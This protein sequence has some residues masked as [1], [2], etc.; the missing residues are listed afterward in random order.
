MVELGHGAANLGNLYRPMSDEDAWA[1]LDAAWECGI[2]AFDTAPHYGL[3]LSERRLG[4]FLATKP[5][6]EY[7]VS[8]KVGRLLRPSPETADRL[9]EPNQFAVPASLKRV[10]DFSADGIRASLEE[11]LERLGLDKV[12]VV[13]L[14]DPDEHD[15]AADLAMG[16]PAVAA[17]RDEGL[18][19]AVGIGSKSTDALVAA[20]RT[21]GLDL[22][23]VAGRYTLL[24]QADEVVA[25]CR[26]T[27]VGIVAAAVFNSGL[28]AKPHPGG[29]YEYGDVPPEML[30]RARRI[31]GV[32]ERH[33]VTLPEAALQFPLREPAVRSVVVGA[34]TPEQVRENVRRMKVEIPEA[35]W[36][37]L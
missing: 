27:G 6:A 2:R 34:A 7:T 13:Y 19:T 17:L 25:A 28:L 29:R 16:V 4:A 31:A 23:M 37:E 30:D 15:L 10:W 3:G 20:V 33:G 18:V 22:A 35:L 11:S 26:E 12:D 9:D 5:R 1:V 24:E 32:C 14:H 36:D 21:E 8:T